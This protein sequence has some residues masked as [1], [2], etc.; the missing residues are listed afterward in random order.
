MINSV[1]PGDFAVFCTVYTTLNRN[2][3]L[4]ENLHFD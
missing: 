1:L 2:R 4:I 3:V